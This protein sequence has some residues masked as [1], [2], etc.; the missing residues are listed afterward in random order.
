MRFLLELALLL[1][2]VVIL[3]LGFIMEEIVKNDPNTLDN[4][5]KIY[6]NL[7][8]FGFALVWTF[9][10][11]FVVLMIIDVVQSFKKDNRQMMDE[12]RRIY[13]YDKIT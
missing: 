10:I 7:G 1:F 3:V 12:A 6:Y 13:Y 9:N 4:Y 8:W 2:F 11:G 5:I